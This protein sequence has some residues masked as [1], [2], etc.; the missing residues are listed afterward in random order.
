MSELREAM[1]HTIDEDYNKALAL[2]TGILVIKIVLTTLGTVRAR[3]VSDSFYSY[4]EDQSAAVVW[5]FNYIFKAMFLVFPLG[6]PGVQA[7][8]DEEAAPALKKSDPI[9]ASDE[10]VV[11]FR[12]V[13]RNA[14]EQEPWFL[15][16]A[17]VYAVTATSKTQVSIKLLYA[18]TTFRWLHWFCYLC[19]L[20]PFRSFFFVFG[21]V[22]M[23]IL[24]VMTILE[25]W[26]S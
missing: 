3:L 7:L 6:K 21:L 24:A 15:A 8:L 12:A 5:I 11:R 9:E 19:G 2:C 13:H 16:L 26:R 22:S 10:T 1:A 14:T 4:G 18:F 23:L 25:G 20:S 17:I